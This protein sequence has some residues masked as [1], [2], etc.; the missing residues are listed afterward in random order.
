MILKTIGEIMLAG[1][2]L[3][4][5]ISA[6]GAILALVGFAVFVLIVRGLCALYEWNE[7]RLDARREAQASR[8]AI[9]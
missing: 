4:I 6:A 8:E 2:L 9:E 3:L 1:L 5:E 7:R